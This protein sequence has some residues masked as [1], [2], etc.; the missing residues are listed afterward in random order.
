M[1]TST[2]A[3]RSAIRP[4]ASLDITPNTTLLIINVTYNQSV[5]QW[6]FPIQ[7]GTQPHTMNLMISTKPNLLW[8]VSE[9][10]MSPFGNACVQPTNFFNTSL[11]NVTSN[12][13]EFKMNYINGT[14]LTSIW[15]YNTIAINNQTFEQLQFGLPKDINGTKDVVIP[16]YIDGQIGLKPY[17]NLILDRFDNQ[18]VGI[19]ISPNGSNGGTITFGGVD[20]SY[21]AGDIAYYPLLPFTETDQQIQF[22]VTNIYVGGFPLNIAGT[23]SLNSEISNIQFDDDTANLIL[24]FLP[25]GKF[26]NGTG[27]INCPIPTFVDL[28]FEFNDQANQKWKLPPY[29]IADNSV[30]TNICNTT[31]TGGAIGTWVFGSAFI[32]NFYMVFDQAKSQFGIAKRT[33]IN[34]GNILTPNIA[35]QLPVIMGAKVQC[36]II[37][38]I[39]DG[40]DSGYN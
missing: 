3:I 30:G 7:I 36:L 21:I 22:S 38:R 37:Y 15:A 32:T 23:V 29:A 10:C 27:T 39:I 5:R 34:Y 11:S 33:D 13:T 25:G 20:S 26:S 2:P 35:V 8:V 24:S 1:T 40:Q 6:F 14:V 12:Y 31:I 16:D 4:H 17:Q 19:A 18:T 28:S 9:L